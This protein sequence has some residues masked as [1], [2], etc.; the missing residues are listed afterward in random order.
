MICWFIVTGIDCETECTATYESTNMLYVVCVRVT[1]TIKL[2]IMD[3]F[4]IWILKL[5]EK[6][7]PNLR[8]LFFDKEKAYFETEAINANR[9]I[10][11]IKLCIN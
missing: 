8:E 2:N 10:W 11:E 4:K 9:N 7:I 3:T 1:R 5:L 6:K